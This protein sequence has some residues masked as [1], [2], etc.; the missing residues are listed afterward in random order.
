[1]K[2]EPGFNSC[3]RDDLNLNTN[4]GNV[5]EFNRRSWSRYLVF[6]ILVFAILVM[7]GVVISNG[8][9]KPAEGERADVLFL[10][11][12][13][14]DKMRERFY[15]TP[16]GSRMM[17]YKWFLALELAD[18]KGLFSD[19]AYLRSLG[20]ISEVNSKG[21]LNPDGLPIGFAIDPV[22]RHETGHWVGL[23]CAACH[24][25]NIEVNGQSVRV[26]GAPTLADFDRFV[27]E[28]GAAL[29]ATMVDTDRFGRFVGR[30]FGSPPSEEELQRFQGLFYGVATK[31][32]GEM[33]MRT[34]PHPSGPGRVDA[35]GEIINALAVFDLQKP[36]NLRPSNA[37]VSYPFLW[38]TPDLAWVQWNPIASN[39]ISRNAGEVL[40]VFGHADFTSLQ[41]PSASPLKDN[42]R[43]KI[44]KV[45]ADL[46]PEEW[47]LKAQE[48][49]DVLKPNEYSEKQTDS[50]NGFLSSSVLYKELYELENWIRELK[51]PRWQEDVMGTINRDLV[52]KGAKLFKNDCRACH[53][54]PP[55]DMTPKQENII[56]KQF[57]KIGRINY[58]KVGTDPTY[59]ENLLTRFTR[60][61]DL[62]DPLFGGKTTVPGGT[63]FLGS[64]G[65]VVEKGLTDMGLSDKEILAYSDYRFYPRKSPEDPLDGYEPPNVD[66]LKAGPLLGIWA[67]G[68]FLHNGSVP[69]LYELLS[70]QEERSKVFWVGNRQLDTEKLGF[71]SD[72]DPD[73]Y[74]FDTSINGNSN[75]GHIYPRRGYSHDQRMA[76]IEYLKDPSLV[77]E[78]GDQ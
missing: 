6:A 21:E 51:H 39:P 36:E 76:L 63:F 62:A 1:M 35:L 5:V 71:I 9:A 61:G 66:S 43:E 13:W 77:K 29:Q 69:N 18:G 11:Q 54:M 28:L 46:V 20:W 33:W 10:D 64:V 49:E 74:R 15:Y 60:T 45:V 23:T 31:L 41:Q 56:G 70:P 55:F 73:L 4:R 22:E 24:T 27:K 3:T 19:P 25:N 38:Y 2:N 26:D 8:H 58:K 34:P 44:G 47:L 12:G 16:Q 42:M 65:A 7:G 59:V 32:I 78:E 17:P 30:V 52:V 37:P 67:T 57:I 72:E 48:Y 75:R 40:G 14:D 53:N 68:P 50:K